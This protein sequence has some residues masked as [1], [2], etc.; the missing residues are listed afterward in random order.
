M[1]VIFVTIFLQVLKDLSL[2]QIQ[3]RDLAGLIDTR[4]KI[5]TAAPRR[6]SWIGLAM[7]HY[8]HGEHGMAIDVMDKLAAA[9]EGGGIANDIVS[10]DLG[11]EVSEAHL[12][13]VT[14]LCAAGRHEEALTILKERAGEIVDDL[15]RRERIAAI[16]LATDQHERAEEAYRFLL[17]ENP[18]NYRYHQGLRAA[19]HLPRAPEAGSP[20]T[21]SP[22]PTEM[23]KL[24]E[25]YSELRA[26]HPKSAACA[27]MR[28]TYSVG[29]AFDAALAAFAGPYLAKGIPSLFQ[30]VRPTLGAP[31][32]AR[33]RDLK[34]VLDARCAT[35]AAELPD[36]QRVWA[37][38]FQAQLAVFSGD[39]EQALLLIDT[40]IA[41]DEEGTVE[42]RL[43]KAEALAA[44]GDYQGA[45]EV[46]DGARRLDLSD[47]YLN[48]V[49]VERFLAAGEIERA[50]TVSGLF[51]NEGSGLNN[52]YQMQALWFELPIAR[53]HAHRGAFATAL[54]KLN[55]I[56]SHFAEFVEDQ[57]D[58]HT[59]S[60]RK[61]MLSAYLDMLGTADGLY[62]DPRFLVAA[63]AA[64][65]ILFR[66]ADNPDLR[67]TPE[68]IEAAHLAGLAKAERKAYLREKERQEEEARAAKKAKELRD[69]D[70]AASA[71][72]ANTQK[73]D[74]DPDGQRWL[75][76]HDPL[77]E[78]EKLVS[79][80]KVF[81]PA[82]PATFRATFELQL[83]LRKP[84]LAVQA[85]T[86]LKDTCGEDH[87]GVP[88]M[89]SRLAAFAASPPGPDESDDP[90]A[91]SQVRMMATL[92]LQKALGGQAGADWAA[93]W[94][95]RW[96]SIPG[97]GL[98]HAAAAAEVTHG[99]LASVLGGSAAALKAWAEKTPLEDGLNL[100]RRLVDPADPLGSGGGEERE[101]AG[102]RWAEALRSVFPRCGVVGGEQ[103]TRR[104]ET[105]EIESDL[106]RVQANIEAFHLV[107]AKDVKKDRKSVV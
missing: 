88:V 52:L 7:A 95:K 36:V 31:G 1:A 72:W 28:L 32:S 81:H 21:T 106:E 2:A 107:V 102:G 94:A 18:E 65:G 37:L 51:T 47:R 101:E 58:F 62:R 87:P 66:A 39:V 19:R 45:A 104:R 60:I 61:F 76:Q 70:K 59:Y 55:K 67:R 50:E 34:P 53:A 29:E 98:A 49:T 15:Q 83:R 105:F 77:V 38:F 42:L 41:K 68:Q 73:P 26:A 48:C 71:T 46:S 27:L 89:A 93:A 40:A 43:C 8:L 97:A 5:L 6:S 91:A 25:L 90:K 16:Y 64:L 17:N 79:L 99:S 80:L 11:L 22:T 54:K 86:G 12:F 30:T 63:D 13:R 3:V 33:F 92:G 4:I 103:A 23:A 44:A 10:G 69:K 24:D 96:A 9:T 75:A 85:L 78:A 56:F 20:L 84:L 82:A 35:W 57:Y 100:W 14:L 74:A